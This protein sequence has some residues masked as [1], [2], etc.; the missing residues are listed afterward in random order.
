MSEDDIEADDASN[1]INPPNNELKR[2]QGIDNTVGT[3]DHGENKRPTLDANSALV[4][5]LLF[6]ILVL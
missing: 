4:L 3:A 1:P 6:A 5:C 2:R